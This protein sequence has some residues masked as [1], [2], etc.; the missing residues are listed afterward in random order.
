M[1][2]QVFPHNLCMCMEK[3]HTQKH[4]PESLPWQANAVVLRVMHHHVCVPT[5]QAG[6]NVALQLTHWALCLLQAV[7][8]SRPDFFLFFL[9][10]V[11]CAMLQPL[12]LKSLQ[13][14]LQVVGMLRFD[15]NQPSLPTSFYSVLLSISIFMALSTVFHSINAPDTS[16][17]SHSVLLVLFLPLWSFQLYISLWK[18]LSALI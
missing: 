5:A 15:I 2:Y 10:A 14:H 18:S 3:G 1:I 16:P 7:Q 6:H 9:P 8:L 12:V 11:L 13:A 17:L 4:T